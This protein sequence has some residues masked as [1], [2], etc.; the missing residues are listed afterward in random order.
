[1]KCRIVMEKSK[2]SYEKCAHSARQ[3][4][5]FFFLCRFIQLPFI[6]IGRLGVDEIKNREKL[7]RLEN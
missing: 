3:A 7:S 1:M 5:C 6:S 2:S 4:F